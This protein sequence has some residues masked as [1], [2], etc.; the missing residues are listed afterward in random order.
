MEAVTALAERFP[1]ARITLD[2]N[3]AWSLKEAI[4]CAATSTMCWPMP[5]TLRRRERLLGP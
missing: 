5:K 3:G 4:A 1:E 2:P